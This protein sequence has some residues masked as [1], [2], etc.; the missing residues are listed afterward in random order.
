MDTDTQK[1]E[2]IE[3]LYRKYYADLKRYSYHCVHNDPKF[4]PYIE[5]CIQETFTKATAN[6]QTLLTHQNVIAWLIMTCG[7]ELRS[8]MRKYARFRKHF[9]GRVQ[10]DVES[11]AANC[12]DLDRWIRQHDAEDDI[13]RIYQALSPREQRVFEDYYANNQSLKKTAKK[14][15]TSENSVH[16]SAKRI[17]KKAGDILKKDFIFLLFLTTIFQFFRID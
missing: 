15:G 6:Y 14:H 17:R 8:C 16:C 3:S 5:D 1:E 11:A 4:T 9:E 2:F 10:I 13:R 12:D 7:N